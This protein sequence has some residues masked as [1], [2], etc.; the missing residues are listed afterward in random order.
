M[1]RIGNI[2]EVKGQKAKV[3]KQKA[4]IKSKTE[5]IPAKAGIPFRKRNFCDPLRDTPLRN[6]TFRSCQRDFKFFTFAFL[7]FTQITSRSF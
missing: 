6:G 4:K 3:R 5:V 7:L 1:P 2:T